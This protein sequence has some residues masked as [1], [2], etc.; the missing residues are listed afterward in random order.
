MGQTPSLWVYIQVQEGTL[1]EEISAQTV[2]VDGV[3]RYVKDMQS[4]T[5]AIPSGRTDDETSDDTGY[6]KTPGRQAAQNGETSEP[7]LQRSTRGLLPTRPCLYCYQ[8]SG[9]SV[10]NS[11]EAVGVT[12]LRQFCRTR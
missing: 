12:S 5:N 2:I 6:I 11:S 9:G 10:E 8:G 1:T 7:P 4:R 3:P